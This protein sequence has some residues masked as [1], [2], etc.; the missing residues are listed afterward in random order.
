[1]VRMSTRCSRLMVLLL[2]S[3]TVSLTAGEMDS[4][5]RYEGEPPQTQLDLRVGAVA[6]HIAPAPIPMNTAKEDVLVLPILVENRSSETITAKLA[7]EWYGG[8]W[9]PTDLQAATRRSTDPAG[10]WEVQPVFLVGEDGSRTP[11]TIWKPGQSHVFAL[12][13]N[14]RGTGSIMASPLIDANAPGKY[15]VR[16][17]FTF[18]TAGS[19]EYYES[20]VMEVVVAEKG[21]GN[22]APELDRLPK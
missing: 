13:L 4:P 21:H 7:H 22:Q 12:R 17:A 20:P 8:R 2:A 15:Q 10:K 5:F 9:P 19:S 14:W 6:T 16:V 11:P 18:K 3:G 1:M